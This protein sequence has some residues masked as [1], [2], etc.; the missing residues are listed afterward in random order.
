[1]E[2]SKPLP[3]A[4]ASLAE[5]RR[6]ENN[7]LLQ[8][9]KPVEQRVAELEGD[10]LRLIDLVLDQERTILDLGK[11]LDRMEERMLYLISLLRKHAD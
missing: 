6:Q 4:V 3:V 9:I 8:A 5:R 7:R 10:T 1:M 11:Q 2:G